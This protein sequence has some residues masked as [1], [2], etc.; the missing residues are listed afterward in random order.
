MTVARILKDKGTDVL[1]T[2][3]HNTLR[4][5]VALL[6]GRK[7]GALVVADASKIP[8]GIISER[9]V[10]RALAAGGGGAL[11]DPVSRHMTAKV[12]TVGMDA[13]IDEVMEIMNTGH[14]RHM[15]V[16]DGAKLAGIVSVS[17]IVKSHVDT[18]HSEHQALRDYISRSA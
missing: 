12:L 2:E 14:F 10:I 17:D 11:D 6:A 13:T 16:V 9:D 5:V 3:P 7:I 15:P 8:V 1:T 18:L 4:E